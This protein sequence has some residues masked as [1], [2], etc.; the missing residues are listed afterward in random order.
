MTNALGAPEPPLLRVT[1]S[2]LRRHCASLCS[3]VVAVCEGRT[4]GH[5]LIVS[6]SAGGRIISF[7]RNGA[8]AG[9]VVRD[10]ISD[11]DATEWVVR[12]PVPGARTSVWLG[13]HETWVHSGRRD[14]WTFAQCGMRLYLADQ[15]RRAAQIL[16]L[17]WVA[18][19]SEAGDSLVYP[20]AHAGQ[21]HW[22]IDRAALFD[23]GEH[24]LLLD[25]LTDP[26]TALPPL[27]AFGADGSVFPDSGPTVDRL[28]YDC[29][30]L[31]A[32]HLPAYAGWMH[33]RW[34]GQTVPG[35][36]Q[37][38]PRDLG[39]LESWWQGALRYVVAELRAHA[40]F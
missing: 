26:G 19:S 15:D 29:S 3:S 32:I 4:G 12:L 39:A 27:E 34:D 21:P 37:T 18:P 30:W 9:L 31:P 8:A 38:A 1:E 7:G 33:E 10:V 23:A 35:P 13:M 14:N 36:Q 5:P 16:R 17:E 20:G 28:S 6:D 2:S 40:S 25:R 24:E 22:H 11:L